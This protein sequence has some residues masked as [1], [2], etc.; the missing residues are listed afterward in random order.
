MPVELDVSRM[1][2]GGYALRLRF[3]AALAGPCMRCLKQ[4]AP[5]V[6]VDSARGRPAGRR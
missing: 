5:I 2:G 3:K 6:E 4:A 1:M